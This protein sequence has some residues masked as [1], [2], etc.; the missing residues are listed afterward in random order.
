MPLDFSKTRYPTDNK[1]KLIRVVGVNVY[2]INAQKHVILQ[3]M[4]SNSCLHA[5]C[6]GLIVFLGCSTSGAQSASNGVVRF[7]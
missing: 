7:Q 4:D 6:R 5:H 1:T 3:L 2:K